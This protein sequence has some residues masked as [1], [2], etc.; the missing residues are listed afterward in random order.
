M[1]QILT[2]SGAV[3]RLTHGIRRIQSVFYGTHEVYDERI[4]GLP[5]IASFTA[6]YGGIN[7]DQSPPAQ[8]TLTFQVA[9]SLHNEITLED[10]TEVPL[11]NDNQATFNR[12]DVTTTYVLH[13]RNAAG[14]ATDTITVVITQAP[15]ISNLRVSYVPRQG[16]GGGATAYF[17]ASWV[18]A[19]TPTFS[20]DQGIG[21]ISARHVNASNKTI[22]FSHY[23]SSSGSRTVRLTASNSQ[24]SAH[25]D[26]VV[27]T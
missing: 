1:S 7:L 24:G 21:A 9:N 25:S 18:G 26:I 23:F 16:I 14:V 6:D 3:I 12:P 5:R 4:A 13:C 22:S 8:I 15:Q 27:R 11:S 17:D 20:A 19:P 2:T 10:G